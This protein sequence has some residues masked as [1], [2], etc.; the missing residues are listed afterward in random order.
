MLP[1]GDNS[2]N[3]HGDS[4]LS[5]GIVQQGRDADNSAHIRRNCNNA[6]GVLRRNYQNKSSGV[7][8]RIFRHRR[9]SVDVRLLVRIRKR[10]R[11]EMVF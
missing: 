2:E 11:V 5:C 3:A 7:D 8:R 1:R 9:N 10:I 6:A 4:I